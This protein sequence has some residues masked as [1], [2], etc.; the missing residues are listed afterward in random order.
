MG[1]YIG[2]KARINRRLG[3]KV[4]DSNGAM[5][6]SSRRFTPPGQ[7]SQRRRRISD[8][9]RALMEKQKIRHYYGLNRCRNKHFRDQRK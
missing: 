5:K 4:Y 1:H 8:Y 3:E 6:A 7:Q 9:G 2:P